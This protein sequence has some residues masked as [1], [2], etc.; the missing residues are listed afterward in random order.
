MMPPTDQPLHP[1]LQILHISDLHLRHALFKP[2]WT[3]RLMLDSLEIIP[4]RMELLGESVQSFWPKIH[5]ALL[6]MAYECEAGLYGHDDDAIDELF[7]WL[8][9]RVMPDPVWK[10]HLTWLIDTG[11]QS[12][13]G[14]DL[15]L[16]YGL[17]TLGRLSAALGNSPST[18]IH[19]NHDAWAGKPPFVTLPRT[20]EQHRDWLRQ[21]HFIADYPADPML[22]HTCLSKTL[23]VDVYQLNSVVHGFVSNSLARGEVCEDRFWAEQPPRRPKRG[24]Q[25]EKFREI[26]EHRHKNQRAPTLRIALMHHPLEHGGKKGFAKELKGAKSL[27][28]ALSD[29]R[30]ELDQE[31][32]AHLVLSGHT[33]RLHPKLKGFQ[34]EA[35]GSAPPRTRQLVIGTAAQR[36]MKTSQDIDSPTKDSSELSLEERYPHQAQL[37]RISQTQPT[38]VSEDTWVAIDRIVIGRANGVAGWRILRETPDDALYERHWIRMKEH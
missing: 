11:D 16:R 36:P 19:G 20:L 37:L 18:R 2:S 1:V 22:T 32:L 25:V 13:F 23:S 9:D 34:D 30:E 14:D 15:S 31:P 8:R 4:R 7:K 5:P 17:E 26:A 12:T 35:S 24:T 3:L 29:P 38:E 27:H 21:S 10:Q 28:K 6:K 33:H